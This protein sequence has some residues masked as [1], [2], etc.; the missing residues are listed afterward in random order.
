MIFELGASDGRRFATLMTEVGFNSDIEEAL[1]LDHRDSPLSRAFQ[2]G[3]RD[4]IK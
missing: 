3:I 4:T 2:G 1:L